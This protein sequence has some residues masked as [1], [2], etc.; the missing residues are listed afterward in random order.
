M[1]YTDESRLPLTQ[2]NGR[3]LVWRRRGGHYMPNVVQEG[4][5]L[6]QGS[7]MVCDGINIDGRTDLDVVWVIL[8]LRGTSNRYCYRIC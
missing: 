8:P 5:R 2:R 3:Q 6:G 1:L 7:V 4:D